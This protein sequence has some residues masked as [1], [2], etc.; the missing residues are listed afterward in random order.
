MGFVIPRRCVGSS[1]YHSNLASMPARADEEEGGD[2]RLKFSF[3]YR[4]I[5][6]HSVR[7]TV[8]AE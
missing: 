5:D 2:G 6:S 1:M 3:K 8:E 7:S 4:E